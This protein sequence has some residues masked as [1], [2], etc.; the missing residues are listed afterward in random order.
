VPLHFLGARRI[1]DVARLPGQLRTQLQRQRP[2][3]LQ[4]FLW[5]ANVLGPLAARGLVADENKKNRVPI[6]T[7]LRVAEPRRRWRWPLERWAAR[8]SDRHAAVSEGVARFARERIGLA[9]E[10]IVVISN[11][12]DVAR[13]PAPP[14]DP[15]SLGVRHGR[16]FLLFVGRLDKQDQKG[17][18]QL[19]EHAPA[20]LN[21]LEQ[22]DLVMVGEGPMT[23]TLRR[24]SAKL[25][26]Q[27]R[28][29]W[30]GWRSDLPAILAAAD[31][32][33]APSRW[34]GMSNVVLEAMVSGK[35]IVAQAAEGIFE[36]LGKQP[37]QVAALN[38]WLGFIDRIAVVA[39]DVELQSRLGEGNRRWAE[40]HFGLDRAVGAYE[41]LYLS[42]I[43][44]PQGYP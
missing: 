17:A 25:G 24:R 4:T 2:A 13:Y 6:V 21:K 22:H 20:L 32:L 19:I 3:L 44:A 1:A 39:S 34:E 9:A 5:H 27:N 15:Q 36:L 41:R 43:E 40:M 8:W 29:H 10:K 30:L 14:I 37:L 23:E 11:G 16:R 28:V 33:I 38:D 35:P 26:L 12:V 18:S 7:G 42:L 31:V